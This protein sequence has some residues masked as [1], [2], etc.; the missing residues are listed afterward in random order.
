M[1]FVAKDTFS[2]WLSDLKSKADIVDVISRYLTVTMKGG[3]YWACCPFHHE[4]TPSFTIDPTRQ[5]FK[6]FGCGES[7]DVISFIMKS[8]SL[9][10]MEAVKKLADMYNVEI[11]QFKNDKSSPSKKA[12]T[13]RLYKV[14]R[15]SALHYHSN[16]NSEFGT[17]GIE[18]LESRGYNE[19]IRTKFGL[20]LSL[21]Y[22]Q[23]PDYLETL[24]F[25]K[26]EML[27]A[28][29]CEEKN[30]KVFDALVGRLIVPVFNIQGNVVAF[31]GRVLGDS[32]FAKYKNTKETPV[33]HKGKE[34]FGVHIVK[35]QKLSARIDDIILVEGHMDVIALN[36]FGIHNTLASMGTAFTENQARLIKR[37]SNNVVLC[38]DGDSAG[39][40]ATARAIDI[41][42]DE[43]L[44]VKVMELPD[45]FDP[46]DMVSKAGVE[47]FLN[48]KRNALGSM[49]YRIKQLSG[50]FNL[51]DLGER[52]KYVAAACE[53]LKKLSSVAEVEVYTDLIHELSEIPKDIIKRQYKDIKVDIIPLE[54]V[55][56]PQAKA[57]KLK[58]KD[59]VYQQSARFVLYSLFENPHV[60]SNMPDFS[61]CFYNPEHT[62]IYDIFKAVQNSENLDESF[63]QTIESD[64]A[65]KTFNYGKEVSASFENVKQKNEFLD[66]CVKNLQS[67]NL[68][69]EMK[70]L[71][72]LHKTETDSEARKEIL[73]AINELNK[74][75]KNI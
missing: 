30:G 43:G 20:G 67:L 29:V 12:E 22:N 41:L 44:T 64:E 36:A 16:L 69:A 59:L 38:F 18:Y 13:D 51:D 74:M 9:E 57:E 17:A 61:I 6:C 46:D 40:T 24:G 19:K 58:G 60:A 66:D 56:K 48:S 65:Q 11:P 35:K 33:F 27:Q 73:I 4:K 42:E 54:L 10:F 1:V 52:A 28:G 8:D 75:I 3:R 32:D 25:T 15:E 47:V 34:L 53:L 72:S 49:E 37:F 71:V 26:D 31:S 55:D 68:T 63:L 7:G 62:K 5:M 45:S 21:G 39:R 70:R 23:L 2:D 14:L 50:Q